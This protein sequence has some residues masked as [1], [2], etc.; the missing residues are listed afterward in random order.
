MILKKLILICGILI[1]L[2][3]KKT[4]AK[5]SG[6]PI[7][8]TAPEYSEAVTQDYSEIQENIDID[9]KAYSKDPKEAVKEANETLVYILE[10]ANKSTSYLR[11]STRSGNFTDFSPFL[12]FKNLETLKIDNYMTDISGITVLS[13]HEKLSEL[14]LWS[15]K[16]TDISPLSALVNLR[17]LYINVDS[18]CTNASELLPLVN[19]ESLGFRPASS[20]TIKNIS[21]LTWLKSLYLSLD[22][23]GLDISPVQNLKNLEDLTIRGPIHKYIEFD[24]SW[25]SQLVNL[26]ELEFKYLNITDISPLLKLPNL[27]KIDVQY[28]VISD[29]NIALLK[30]TGATVWTYADA[31]R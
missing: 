6:M 13:Q 25:I 5:P 30:K 23:E 3:C 18:T 28:S 4:A 15:K 19:L 2:G 29:E 20:E 24:I 12:A 17:S 14:I 16:V 8:T 1:L 7:P 22:Y 26:Q 21:R 31:D 9:F 10:K 11:I 27:K